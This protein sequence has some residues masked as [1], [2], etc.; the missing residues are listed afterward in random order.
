MELDGSKQEVLVNE[1][2]KFLYATDEKLYYCY[3][4]A[5][6]GLMAKSLNDITDQI[7]IN[8]EVNSPI[9]LKN[10]IFYLNNKGNIC[11]IANI[12]PV[13]SE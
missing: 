6:A 12:V 13:Q 5:E 3:S 8:E 4:G 10:A 9:I 1:P 7:I 11:R 2:C